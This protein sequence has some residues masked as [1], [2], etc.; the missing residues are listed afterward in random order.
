M[1]NAV[2]CFLFVSPLKTLLE[3]KKMILNDNSLFL[4]CAAAMPAEK[5]FIEFYMD[6]ALR[7]GYVNQESIHS[8][9]M[10]NRD[11]LQAAET[12]LST[13]IAGKKQH[14]HWAATGSEAVSL[15][16]VV[17]ATLIP[18]DQKVLITPDHHKSVI[19]SFERN[20]GKDRVIYCPIQSSG[21]IQ[22]EQFN[23]ILSTE[24]IGLVGLPHVVS[25]TGY[26]YDL[27]AVRKAMDN[28]QSKAYLFVDMVQ[29]T[30][31]VPSCFE[32]AKIDFAVCS[33][34]KLGTIPVS[35]VIY[36]P[37]VACKIFDDMRHQYRA[38][39]PDLPSCE[40]LAYAVETFYKQM[41]E[42]NNECQ[43][44]K[45]TYRDALQKLSDAQNLNIHFFNDASASPWILSFCLPKYQGAVLVRMLGQNGV[46]LGSGSACQ[47]ENPNPSYVLSAMDIPR[48][49]AFGL[50]RLSFSPICK[51]DEVPRF[52]NTLTDVLKAY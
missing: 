7:N 8:V 32:S 11:R 30:G 16:G 41:P 51:L 17:L 3:S 12:R 34:H 42:H 4:D 29:S 31:K 40:T 44:L 5:K 39:R 24:P 49:V 20:F 33:A 21:A 47:S 18:S 36:R 1:K 6:C 50:L 14:I 35:A 27:N 10:K 23:K 28:A 22:W 45:E 37:D 26:V 15:L 9:A 19:A 46:H 2:I 43:K 48:D 52:I 13:A 25:E 38:G